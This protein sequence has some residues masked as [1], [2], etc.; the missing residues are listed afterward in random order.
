MRVRPTSARQGDCCVDS[1]SAELQPKIFARD[2]RLEAPLSL[3]IP[4][5][6][7]LSFSVKI[8]LLAPNQLSN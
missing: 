7:N 2:L 5:T 3:L 6:R 4:L 8:C 1:V